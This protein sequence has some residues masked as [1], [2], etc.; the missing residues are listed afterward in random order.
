M[1]NTDYDMQAKTNEVLNLYELHSDP[2]WECMAQ[3]VCSY[4]YFLLT[5]FHFGIQIMVANTY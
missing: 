5:C 1:S 4:T 2:F 3:M